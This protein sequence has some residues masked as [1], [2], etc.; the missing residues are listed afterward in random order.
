[1]GLVFAALLTGCGFDNYETVP[2]KTERVLV[3]RPYAFFNRTAGV[4]ILGPLIPGKRN[5][6]NGPVVAY[7]V[8]MSLQTSKHQMQVKVADN[9][10]Q[11]FQIGVTWQIKPGQSVP[12]VLNFH[13]PDLYEDGDVN[14]ELSRMNNVQNWNI[15]LN[16]IYT[17]NLQPFIEMAARDVIDEFT[18]E[19]V[20]IN[21]LAV[22]IKQRIEQVLIN[23]KFPA[24]VLDES[25]QS[26]FDP[27]QLIS[28]LD[29][30][31]I[32]AVT[33]LGYQQPDLIR[34]QITAIE[35][36]KNE[37]KKLEEQ[38]EQKK[39]DKAQKIYEAQKLAEIN[40]NTKKLLKSRPNLLPYKKYASL[41]EIIEKGES[42]GTEL[43][44]LPVGQMDK[45]VHQ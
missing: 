33:I 15:N 29:V 1:M 32:S 8:D 35:Q 22:K 3:K 24:T 13:R 5:H 36:L 2:E 7:D 10:M 27:S 9:I 31:D 26:V 42:S 21:L 12:L 30:V 43:I 4:E 39:I 14:V 18:S 45:R 16:L 34:D 6:S 20:E 41:K 25:G 19:N 40:N 17:I 28:I 23:I 38:K 44:L 37:A 11:P